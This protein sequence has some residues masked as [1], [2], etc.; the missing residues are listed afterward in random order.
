MNLIKKNSVR[1]DFLDLVEYKLI[2]LATSKLTT[3]PSNKQNKI[4]LCKPL[5]HVKICTYTITCFYFM[6]TKGAINNPV[7]PPI[8]D[9][10]LKNFHFKL[11]MGWV[12]F[13]KNRRIPPHFEQPK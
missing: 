5:I 13:R 3:F 10:H 11:I 2:R 12:Q 4:D 9:N 6:G 1:P 8:F 7:H